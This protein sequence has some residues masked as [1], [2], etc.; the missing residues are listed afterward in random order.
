M[1][2]LVCGRPYLE[3]TQCPRAFGVHYTLRDPL[4]VEVSKVIHQVE[5]LVSPQ[6]GII[7]KS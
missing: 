1:G 3:I 7:I 5:I 6:S 4:T 2:A